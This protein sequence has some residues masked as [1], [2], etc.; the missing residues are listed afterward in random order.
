MHK[1]N[2]S[3]PTLNNRGNFDIHENRQWHFDFQPNNH[4]HGVTQG[5]S[6]KLK[7]LYFQ[8][9]RRYSSKSCEKI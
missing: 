4:Y 8:N 7:M 2:F 3:L 5:E 6:R 9:E 1:E